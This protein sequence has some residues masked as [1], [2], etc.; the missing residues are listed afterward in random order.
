MES[1]A[2]ME[3]GDR[4]YDN[5]KEDASVSNHIDILKEMDSFLEDID[6]GLI[7]SRMVGDSVI[8]GM[9]NAVEE[10][11]AERIAQKELEVVGLK[12]I[13]DEFRVGS[14]ETKTLWSLVHHREPDEV[15]M[16]QFPDS[17]V[18]HDRCIMSVDSFQIAVHEQLNQ[19]RKEVNKIRGASSI[20][21][22][23]SGSDLVGLG[24]IL[25][26]N[27]PEK[28]IYVN[29]AFE[30]LKDTLDTFCRRMEDMD[31]LSKASLS[32]WQQEQDFCS[33]IERM[34]ISNSIWGLQQQFEQKL[35]DLY[36]SESRNCFNQYK[37]ISSLRQ[38]L[39]AIFKTLSVSET[40]HLLSHG[41]LEN[42]DEW[43]HNKRVDHF[44]VKLSTDPLSPSTM[45]ENGKQEESKINKPENLDSAS[46]KHMSKE[47]L[48]TY[49]TKMR[50]NHESQV[51]EKTEENFRLRRELLNLK[52]RGSSFPLKKDKEFEL[53][54]KKIPDV[55]SKLNEIL[56]GN[57]KV[58][59]FSENIESLSSLKDR[60]D[61][62]QLENHQL[63]DTLSDMKKEF[64]S[65]S[66]Q[67][68]AS[69]E[70]LSQQQLTQKNLLQ[71]IQKL[72]DD[73][74]DAHTQVSVIQDVYKCFFEDIVSE[75]RYSTEELHLKNSF[76]QEIYEVI[77]K[78]ASHSAQASS[79]LGIEEAEMESTIM[80]GQLD[81]N[82]IIFKETLMNADEA[83][84]FE[85]AEKET[86]KYEMLMLNSVVEEKEKLIQGAADALVLEKQKTESA[87]E[88]LNSLRA[89]IVQ[90]HKLIAE[91]SK[92]LNVTKG[93]L[94]AALKEIEQYKE[95]VQELHQNLEQRMNKLKETD[96]EK[97]V[98]CTLT[99]KQQET[100]KLIE[101]KE[102]ES[103]KQMESTINLI[104][105]LLAMVT[106]FE[107]RV[108]KDISRNRLSLE[109]MR[110][111]FH[112]IKNKANVLKTMGLV[113]KQRLE[114]K[115]SDLLKAEAEVDLLGD[116]VDT[117][118]S[119]L[120]KIYIA[121]DHYSPIL[122]HYPGIIEILEL[123]RRELT[124]DSRKHV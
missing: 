31:H 29:K 113:H 34:V 120:E 26:E 5:G 71:T 66:S 43:C 76:M 70:K 39:D 81:I 15:G 57:E 23:S 3:G 19:L 1:S 114:T 117:L 58:H 48:V 35:L 20:R 62:L 68:S 25:Q 92:E 74:G 51:Q 65:L 67:L 6:E 11:A 41:S 77:F 40:G 33:E 55:I 109:N 73:I 96:E 104:Y 21:R 97:K 64:K 115:S 80:Q 78:E 24:G 119:L 103:R 44:H 30:S 87:S 56:D 52:E 10:Q 95:Q 101:E 8:K 9:V 54:K 124:G 37:E 94:V 13:L 82:H 45:E 7:I 98:L 112:W 60:L 102:R 38:E 28:W 16:H 22:I 42:T 84:K 49:I 32:E 27:M 118:L 59:Q 89:E 107:A 63:K 72:E 90:Q 75:F 53:L 83:L 88:Q 99:Q 61:F 4:I 116:E 17:V 69:V 47:D 36:D 111:E 93:N 123:V 14:D 2:A 46:L 105:K 110:S 121:L 100:L 79:G 91:N 106:D 50:R 12:K 122:Q 86:L 85:S 18:G 108:N